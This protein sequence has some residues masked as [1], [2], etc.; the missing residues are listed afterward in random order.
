MARKYKPATDQIVL[1]RLA[2]GTLKVDT[3]EAVAFVRKRPDQEWRQL[4]TY[5]SGPR[6]KYERVRLYRNGAR[7]SIQLHR[8]VWVAANRLAVPE[9]CEIHHRRA[10]WRNGIDHIECVSV[11]RHKAL[12]YGDDVEAFLNS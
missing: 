7:K 9:G 11:V 4:R 1:D 6:E 10:R 2:D 3:K 5:S 8:L 12:T